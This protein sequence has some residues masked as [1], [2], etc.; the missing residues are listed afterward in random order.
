MIP[1]GVFTVC[2]LCTVHNSVHVFDWCKLAWFG[3]VGVFE[4]AMFTKTVE[5]YFVKPSCR[6]RRR[7]CCWFPIN[8][9][10][11]SLCSFQRNSVTI[12]SLGLC[13]YASICPSVSLSMAPNGYFQ[14]GCNSKVFGYD[15]NTL[16]NANSAINVYFKIYHH[17]KRRVRLAFYI[18]ISIYMHTKMQTFYGEEMR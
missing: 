11:L 16:V 12:F 4:M 6:R 5:R 7:C 2:A 9:R 3:R 8:V 13:M 1:L 15:K 17:S 10:K 14:T 18:Y